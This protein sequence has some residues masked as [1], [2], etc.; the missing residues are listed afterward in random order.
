[1]P[2]SE[3]ERRKGTRTKRERARWDVST[4]AELLALAGLEDEDAIMP[5]RE[6]AYGRL[7][8]VGLWVRKDADEHLIYVGLTVVELVILRLHTIYNV[9]EVKTIARLM[10]YSPVHIRNLVRGLV[11]RGYLER[12]A[13]AKDRR[14]FPTAIT[15]QG[16][17]LHEEAHVAQDV[18]RAFEVIDEARRQQMYHGLKDVR[19]IDT[20]FA[21]GSTGK[22]RGELRREMILKREGKL[23]TDPD[24]RI[25][26]PRR[27]RLPR[28]GASGKDAPRTAAPV[29]SG[30]RPTTAKPKEGDARDPWSI[31]P[32]EWVRML[33]EDV[34]SSEDEPRVETFDDTS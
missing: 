8:S 2:R 29:E 30:R 23:P 11:H 28:A 4:N 16:R 3:G 25:P 22:T 17:A 19:A 26:R 7:V 14:C 10:K 21:R 12:L 27:T 31:P 20:D 24:G 32:D 33:L 15:E 34:P 5:S 13:Q 9:L 6:E 1:M 18:G